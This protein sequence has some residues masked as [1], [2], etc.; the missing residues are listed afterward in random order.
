MLNSNLSSK[1]IFNAIYSDIK[2][3]RPT[4]NIDIYKVYYYILN[5]N[6]R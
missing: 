1:M 6:T 4:L 5:V 2:S 3:G